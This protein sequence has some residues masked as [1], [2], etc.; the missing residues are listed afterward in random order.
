L[1]SIHDGSDQVPHKRGR[2]APIGN[3]NRLTHGRYTREL[4]ELRKLVRQRVRA[5]RHAIA[6]ALA[7][8]AVEK[9]ITR[10]NK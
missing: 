10:K 3:R 7:A 9:A 5:A 1:N 4:R 6:I 8:R 2:G